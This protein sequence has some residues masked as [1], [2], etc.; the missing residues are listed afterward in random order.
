M[1]DGQTDAGSGA[2]PL[3]QACGLT[4]TIGGQVLIDGLDVSIAR[5]RR[6]V[7]LGANGSGKS[8][9]LRLLH[10]LIP[11]SG[12]EILW[13]G[14][15]ADPVA[16]RAQAMV[17]QRPVLLRR[18]VRANLRFAL[19]VHGLRGRE[20]DHRVDQVLEMARLTDLAARPAR[21]LSGGEQQRLAVARA[22]AM[23]PRLL[24]LDEPT[25][26]L[27]PASTQAVEDLILQADADGVAIVMV[28]HDAGQARRIGQEAAFLHA[29][30]VAESGPVADVLDAPKSRPAQA[31]R[32]GQI[33][34]EPAE[35]KAPVQG[36]KA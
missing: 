14:R 6:T 9:M 29:G 12:G 27:D 15:P 26:S 21:V 28:T 19:G 1:L 17:F 25:A 32:D 31:W 4:L 23:S 13:Q 24:F 2:E 35:E 7:I 20:R 16:Q 5:G 8:L 18:S 3:L 36:K 34:I 11:P 10:G 33:Y 30:Q 22:L